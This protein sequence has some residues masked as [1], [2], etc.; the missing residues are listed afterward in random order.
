MNVLEVCVQ[1][2]GTTN[3]KFSWEESQLKL[4]RRY[5]H[6]CACV[7][8]YGWTMVN[9]PWIWI[10]IWR[11]RRFFLCHQE[12]FNA[13]KKNWHHHK[14]KHKHHIVFGWIELADQIESCGYC[15]MRR[16]ADETIE[17]GANYFI[18]ITAASSFLSRIQATLNHLIH[19]NWLSCDRLIGW[20]PNEAQREPKER[21]R[22]SMLSNYY[23]Q[24]ASCE[25]V[26]FNLPND[27]N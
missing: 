14:H 1:F 10:P 16:I 21:R 17:S 27:L 26:N 24:P 6:M 15:C 5:I 2:V 8:P 9:L 22:G 19:N 13:T 11:F 3:E 12:K 20:S 23:H 25:T 18:Q 4:L 7:L